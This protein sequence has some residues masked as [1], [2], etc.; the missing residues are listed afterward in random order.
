MTTHLAKCK[1]TKYKGQVFST[2]LFY[3]ILNISFSLFLSLFLNNNIALTHSLGVCYY[4]HWFSVLTKDAVLFV[5]CDSSQQAA[6]TVM[7]RRA[8]PLET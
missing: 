6:R 3:K 8:L 1:K 2:I 4:N 5:Q 7:H